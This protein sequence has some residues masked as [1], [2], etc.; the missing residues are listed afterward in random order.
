MSDIES[1]ID[2]IKFLDN[3]WL[4][5]RDHDIVREFIFDFI[6]YKSKQTCQYC[7]KRDALLTKETC[8]TGCRKL[9]IKEK[10]I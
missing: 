6:G 5:G 8:C 1:K 4:S 7:T 9:T 10:M 2:M 3:Y